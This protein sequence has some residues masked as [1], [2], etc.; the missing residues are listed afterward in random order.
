MDNTFINQHNLSQSI[1]NAGNAGVIQNLAGRV[2]NVDSLLS[3]KASYAS[4]MNTINTIPGVS[5]ALNSLTNN[6]LASLTQFSGL[7]LQGGLPSLASLTGGSAGTGVGA[8]ANNPLAEA[9]NIASS[10]G[11]SSIPSSITGVVQLAL[12]VKTIA[13]NLKI[14]SITAPDIQSLL[15]INFTAVEKQIGELLLHEVQGIVGEILDPIKLILNQLSQFFSPEKIKKL[16]ASI[17]PDVNDLIK[18]TVNQLTKCNDGPGAKKNDLSGKNPTGTAPADVPSDIIPPAPSTGQAVLDSANTG[19]DGQKYD[20]NA[21]AYNQVNSATSPALA[22][23]PAA[24]GTETDYDK[25]G[26]V[27]SSKSFDASG[28]TT[29]TSGPAPAPGTLSAPPSIQPTPKVT[30]SQNSRTPVW[31]AGS[32]AQIDALNSGKLK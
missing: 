1:F 27:V 8:G 17:I 11:A 25:N 18:N 19:N 10:V 14:P 20:S 5:N 7:N 6:P 3:G 28:N 16:L 32:Q 30:P 4:A 13:C 23:T 15:K 12:Q 21:N 2:P 9:F 31:S 22:T 24:G 26:N 29:S